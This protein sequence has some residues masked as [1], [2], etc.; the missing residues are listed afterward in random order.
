[1]EIPDNRIYEAGSPA[2]LRA[3]RKSPDISMSG[4]GSVRSFLITPTS[5][6]RHWDEL[7]RSYASGAFNVRSV[8]SSL[9]L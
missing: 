8:T 3:G 7:A 6:G 2:L 4:N 9:P 1:V 5:D